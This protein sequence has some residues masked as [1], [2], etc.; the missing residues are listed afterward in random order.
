MSLA[1]DQRFLKISEILHIKNHNW[2][3]IAIHLI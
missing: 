3:D 2:L 1:M